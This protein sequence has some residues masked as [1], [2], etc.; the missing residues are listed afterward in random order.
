MSFLRKRILA[1]VAVVAATA[2]LVTVGATPAAADTVRVN[3]R[4][5]LDRVVIPR[6]FDI[7]ITA[8]ATAARGQAVTVAATVSDIVPSSTHIPA[9]SG[10]WVLTIHLG[11]AATGS[12][13][14]NMTNPEIQ[15]GTPWRITGSGQVTLPA[16]GTVTYRPGIAARRLVS[17]SCGPADP[18]SVP[19]AATTRVS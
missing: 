7:T 14:I 16:A 2:G 10:D 13:R 4:C 6:T 3:Y 9:N 8:P 1:G 12:P 5:A 11:G 17:Y 15:P 19:V 18:D